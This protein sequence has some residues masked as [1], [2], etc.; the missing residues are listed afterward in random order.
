[1]R[2]C[3]HY[4]PKSRPFFFQL[5]ERLIP[6]AQASFSELSFYRTYQNRESYARD[7]VNIE[8]TEEDDKVEEDDDDDVTPSTPLRSPNDGNVTLRINHLPCD[9]EEEDEVEDG[10]R[11][12]NY[13]RHSKPPQQNR[14]QQSGSSG[15]NENSK[16]MSISSSDGSKDSKA[17]TCSAN[18]SVVNGRIGIQ[19]HNEMGC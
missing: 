8:L 1:M 9:E 18:G 12:T 5:I 16:G 4:N 14:R 2:D 7:V 11:P 19:W 17:S 10:V 13:V 6:Y 15:N 3:W